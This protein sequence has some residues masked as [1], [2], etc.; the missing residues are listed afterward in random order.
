MTQQLT[1]HAIFA[2]GISYTHRNKTIAELGMVSP[3]LLK[4]F[5]IKQA[6]YFADVHWYNIMAL[7]DQ[8]DVKMKAVP[9][10]PAVRRDLALV[11][12]KQVSF[13]AM[14]AIALKAEKKL[15]KEIGLFDVFEGKPLEE[16]KKSYS[17]RFILQD[18]NKTLNDKQIDK[19]MNKL[20]ALYEKELGALIRR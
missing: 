6:V 16:G 17:L 10:Y 12:D 11:V 7:A 15:I 14:K 19:L 18:E 9:K 2:Q 3:K 1:E 4:Q 20:I 5:G 13:Q 8:H